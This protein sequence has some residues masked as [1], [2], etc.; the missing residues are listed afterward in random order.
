VRA[1][2]V[3]ELAADVIHQINNLMTGLLINA[4]VLATQG[5]ERQD[6]VPEIADDILVGLRQCRSLSSCFLRLAQRPGSREVGQRVQLEELLR[7]L[8]ILFQHRFQRAGQR[9][10]LQVGPPPPLGRP[11]HPDLALILVELLLAAV[12]TGGPGA[13]TVFALSF[14]DGS[15]DAHLLREPGEPEARGQPAA[16]QPA[17]EEQGFDLSLCRELA[18][19]IDATLTAAAPGP[20]GW[21]ARLRVTPPEEA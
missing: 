4:E 2:R 8:E 18:A 19:G 9:L 3:A 10:D 21:E 14:E 12:R 5:R 16:S 13:R 7:G 6:E 17:G 11:H 20:G 1:A 15:V